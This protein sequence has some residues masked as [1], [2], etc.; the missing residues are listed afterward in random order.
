MNVLDLKKF[1]SS[2]R[3]MLKD[4]APNECFHKDENCSQKIIKSHSIQE[5]KI[6]K[7][8]SENG[9][10]VCLDISKSMNAPTFNPIGKKRATTF[11][12][13]CSYHDTHLFK[14]IENKD[15]K[16]GN[17]EQE[18]LF[19]YR[20]LARGHYA[21]KI[22][23][24]TSKFIKQNP[25]NLVPYFNI[26]SHMPK[27]EAEVFYIANKDAFNQIEKHKTVFNISLSKKHYFKVCTDTIVFEQEFPVAVCQYCTVEDDFEGNI[28]NDLGN[29]YSELYYSFISIFP[30]NGKTYV[31]ISY[32]KKHRNTNIANLGKYLLKQ[33]ENDQKIMISNL[34]LTC[35]ENFVISPKT[36]GSF[37]DDQKE[38][39]AQIFGTSAFSAKGFLSNLQDINLFF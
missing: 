1:N 21:K 33:S 38:L 25:N 30:Q 3:K 18:F 2:M 5:N 31:L 11:R 20:A 34:I 12:G 29:L 36:W 10:V 4:I 26:P 39:I 37:S 27:N 28:I 8:I 22:A 14:S 16:I 6:L 9:L 24:Y 15:Y 35:C 23:F 13:F 32:M 7:R 19:A 17:K